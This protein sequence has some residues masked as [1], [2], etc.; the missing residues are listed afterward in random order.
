LFRSGAELFVLADGAEAVESAA[1]AQLPDR[2][3]VLG[4]ESR[5]GLVRNWNR[6]LGT[7]TGSF[8]HVM[9]DDD[10][11]AAGFYEAI[12]ALAARFPEAS[13]LATGTFSSSG[14][15]PSAPIL[16]QGSEVAEV[17]LVQNRHACGSAVIARRA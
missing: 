9:H 17:L 13:L 10:E 4:S 11:V 8:V 3:V 15:A 2:C 14:S 16:R 6:C 12:L 1:G 7:G 5:L